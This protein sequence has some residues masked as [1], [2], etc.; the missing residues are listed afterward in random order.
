MSALNKVFH[1]AMLKITE[2][3]Q[4]LKQAQDR[5]SGIQEENEELVKLLTE[6]VKHCEYGAKQ[7]ADA[8]NNG[9]PTRQTIAINKA[10]AYLE[11]YK[12]NAQ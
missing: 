12:Y 9:E 10:R 6:L 8:W 3:E 4:Q 7:W 11:K 1:K 2:L 5:L